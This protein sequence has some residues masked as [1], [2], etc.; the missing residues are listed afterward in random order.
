MRLIPL[1]SALI[2]GAP[3]WAHEF[4]VSPEA[5]TIAPQDQLVAALRVGE[6]FEGGASPFLPSRHIRFDILHQGSVRPV[7]GRIGDRPALANDAPGEGL[8]TVV[9][10]TTNNTLTYTEMAKFEKFARHKDFAWAIEQHATRGLPQAGFK[11]VYS[12]Y[13]KSLIAVGAGDGADQEVGL[14]TEIV[15]LANPYTDDI[16]AGLP[17]KVLYQGAPRADA[18]V[19]LFERAPGGGVAVTLHR[20]DA[21][22]VAVIPVKTGHEY[23]VDAVVLRPVESQDPSAPVWESLWAALTFMA[24]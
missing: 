18:Q 5:Y 19:E 6:N 7:T 13:A 10:Q 12:R 14:L 23:L 21:D 20:T 24:P 16:S 11:E 22:G 3:A 4:W 15:A 2:L 17:V 8:V 9:H 1:L